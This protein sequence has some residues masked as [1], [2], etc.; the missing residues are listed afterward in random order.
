M[1]RTKLSQT[2]KVL[3]ISYDFPPARS[4][5]VYRPTKFIKHL[6]R[7]GWQPIVLTA[8]NP[9]VSD[10]DDTLLRDVPP[11]TPIHRVLAP[12]FLALDNFL[13]RL[14]FGNPATTPPASTAN[15]SP[16]QREKSPRSLNKPNWLKQYLFRP[17]REL[18]EDWVYI[19]D[20]KSPW[21][22]F[23]LGKALGIIDR[24]NPDVILTTSAPHTAQLIGLTL[25]V[26]TRRPWIAD[27]RDNWVLGYRQ[28]YRDQR[29]A[30]L[31]EWLM[32]TIIKHAD[33]VVAMSEGNAVDIRSHFARDIQ[34]NVWAIPNG[35][36]D[37]DFADLPV[38]SHDSHSAEHFVLL[39]MGTVY[40]QSYGRFFHA[41]AALLAENEG[42]RE[43]ITVEF[44]GYPTP[45][46]RQLAR[47][48]NLEGVVRFLG[49]KSHPEALRAMQQADVLLLFL[50]GEKILNQQYPGKVFEYLR[51]QRPILTLGDHGEIVDT[52]QASGCGV[53]AHYDN[54]EQIK[55]ALHRLYTSW[56][57]GNLST[58]PNPE[59]INQFEYRALTEKLVAV[60]EAARKG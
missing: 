25:K 34:S 30:A 15:R 37:D 18:I 8:K 24:E 45:A 7:W 48:L 49:F 27:F 42:W 29:R 57:Q 32:K 35:F 33:Q 28:N 50:G 17:A 41:L 40:G 47:E 59:I 11:G 26:I 19:P 5:G 22:P 3:I 56:S 12:D 31:D 9:F 36:D 13:Y 55:T 60:L 21:Y 46:C 2:G 23:A 14:F 1:E 53:P 44:I 39:H 54:T 6:G 51:T 20:S 38:N 10:Y 43:K 4:S 58:N 52:M 16:Q